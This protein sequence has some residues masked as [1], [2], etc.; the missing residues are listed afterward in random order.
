[1]FTRSWAEI[2]RANYSPSKKA[3]H[4]IRWNL[5]P[6]HIRQL[7]GDQAILQLEHIHPADV[8]VAPGVR[9]AHDT[10]V[11]EAEDFLDVNVGVRR[12]AEESLPKFGY[13]ILA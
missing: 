11:A 6:F 7:L 1:M 13:C 8:T 4:L 2:A 12:V 10:A 5:S 3:G 9:P